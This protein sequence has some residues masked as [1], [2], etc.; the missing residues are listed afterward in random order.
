MDYLQYY[1]EVLFFVDSVSIVLNLIINGLPS[2]RE[3][4]ENNEDY[5]LFVVLN[6]IINGLPS[7]QTTSD[8]SDIIYVSSVLNLIINGLPSIL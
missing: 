7:I 5:K 2:I 6:L 8:G 4:K 3:K 1:R